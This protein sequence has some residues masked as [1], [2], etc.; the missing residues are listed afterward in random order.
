M[1][2]R[3]SQLRPLRVVAPA[4]IMIMMMEAVSSL[5][6]VIYFFR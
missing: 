2:A 1:L 6:S 4:T 5:R 3:T